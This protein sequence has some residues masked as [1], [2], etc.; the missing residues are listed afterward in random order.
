MEWERLVPLFHPVLVILL[1]PPFLVRFLFRRLWTE[2]KHF[3][4]I[5]TNSRLEF[6][7]RLIL[8]RH[9]CLERER[10]RERE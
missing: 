3:Y 10:E 2:A 9:L 4:K 7:L 1:S 8:W 5:F 6:C